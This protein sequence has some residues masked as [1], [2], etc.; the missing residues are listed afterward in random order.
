MQDYQTLLTEHD[1]MDALAEQLLEIARGTCDVQAALETRAKLS[2]DLDD[3][4]SREDSFLYDEA[5]GATRTSFPAAVL[6]FRQTFA[7]LTADWSDYLRTW[8]A[9]CITV[10]WAMFAAETTAITHRLR[11]RIAEEND[12]LYPLALHQSHIRLRAAA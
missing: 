5:M 8:D 11:E 2:V 7:D 10:D 4:L 12:I 1:G 3:H 6:R 9:D